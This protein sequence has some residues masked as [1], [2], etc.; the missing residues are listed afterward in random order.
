M[1]DLLWRPLASLAAITVAVLTASHPAIGADP[2]AR[3]VLLIVTDDMNNDLGCYGHPRVQSP[4]LDR[5]SERG[6]RFERA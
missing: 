6:T 1:P 5:L 3:N 4:H 2:S